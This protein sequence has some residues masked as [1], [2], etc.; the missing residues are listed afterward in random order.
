[1]S[2]IN[3]QWELTEENFRRM[4]TDT[5]ETDIFGSVR[6]GEYLVEFRMTNPGMYDEPHFLTTD[7][8]HFGEEGCEEYYLCDGT[9]Y[10][11]LDEEFDIPRRRSLDGFKRAVEKEVIERVTTHRF[12]G[13]YK[14]EISTLLAARPTLSHE[15]WNPKSG[16]KEAWTGDQDL[17]VQ[18]RL[19]TIVVSS[20]DGGGDY[21]G[22]WIGL[23]RKGRRFDVA[24]VEVDQDPYDDPNLLKVHVYCTDP[25]HDDPIYAY[26][27]D[28]AEIDKYNDAM[29]E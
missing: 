19:G 1:M 5:A 6:F 24:M 22:V 2:R 4:F 13:N 18:T 9:P 20:K 15:A 16:A 28:A 8:Y 26:T 10:H 11:I 25:A 3:F 14:S 27:T 23:E 7:V 17:R 29:N 21:P 12:W